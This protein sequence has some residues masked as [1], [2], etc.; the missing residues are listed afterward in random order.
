MVL[1]AELKAEH[2]LSHIELSPEHTLS[3]TNVKVAQIVSQLVTNRYIAAIIAIMA[4]TQ[5]PPINAP[6]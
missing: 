6:A 5:G 1:H 4:I 2:T 3:Q